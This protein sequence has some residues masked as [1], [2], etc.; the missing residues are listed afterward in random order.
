MPILGIPIYIAKGGRGGKDHSPSLDRIRPKLGYVPGNVIVISNRANRLKSD[1]TIR[2]LRDIASFYATLREG[3]R[4]TGA[5]YGK[6][7]E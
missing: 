1:A 3:V 5:A 6:E 4:V 2:E 7:T